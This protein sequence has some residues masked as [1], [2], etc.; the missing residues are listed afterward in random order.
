M[1][2]INYIK[3]LFSKGAESSKGALH[4]LFEIEEPFNSLYDSGLKITETPDRGVK[5]RARFY[6]LINLLKST[7]DIEGAV[8]E[9]GCWKGLSSYLMCEFTRLESPAFQGENFIIF[10]S[11]EGLSLPRGEDKITMKLVD[12]VRNRQDTFFKAAGAYDASMDHVKN[13]LKDF[14]KVEYHKG[15][16]PKY[17]EGYTPPPIKFLHIDVD[18]YEP[19]IGTLEKLFPY[20][21]TGGV[22][23]CDDYGSLYWPG[24]KKAIEEFSEKKN[25][26]FIALSTGQAVFMKR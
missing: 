20:M 16:L 26:K 5:R 11:F 15:W 10:D 14:P 8:I 18:L 12:N 9:C 6:N 24:A 22:V 25:I 21:V 1:N 2:L 4:L 13:V 23:V 3:R 7:N 17:L 19:I